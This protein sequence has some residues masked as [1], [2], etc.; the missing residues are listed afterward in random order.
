M[1]IL[2]P[3]YPDQVL[4]SH[5]ELKCKLTGEVKLAP[6][7][8][9]ELLTLRRVFARPMIVTSCCR[10]WQHNKNEGGHE[11]SLHVY[12][13][14]HHPTGGTVAIDIRC[15]DGVYMLELIGIARSLGWSIGV[16]RWGLHLDRRD[17]IGF[18]Q[19]AFG[20]G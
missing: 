4:F 14:P 16:A 12:D 5:D 17:L 10:S 11:H 3:D 19:V 7:F 18:P 6:R 13:K 9:G 8:E 15:P 20:Y 2:N 1:D